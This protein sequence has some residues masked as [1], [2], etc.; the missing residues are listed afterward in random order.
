MNE[1]K[2]TVN[3]GERLFPTSYYVTDLIDGFE[4][5]DHKLSQR[6][7]RVLQKAAFESAFGVTF[8][9]P[10]Y[11]KTRRLV[12]SNPDLIS[13][14]VAYGRSE[15]GIW[16]RFNRAAELG[17]SDTHS[18]GS[19][20]E[21]DIAQEDNQG[22]NEAT[23]EEQLQVPNAGNEDNLNGDVE[24]NIDWSQHCMYCDELLPANPSQQL[25]D[26][27]DDLDLRSVHDGVNGHDASLNPRH[28]FIQPIVQ[29]IK[30]CQR[31]WFELTDYPRAANNTTWFGALPV[32]FDSLPSRVRALEP[33]LNEVYMNPFD[34]AF[35]EDLSGHGLGLA[36][37]YASM[38]TTSAG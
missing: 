22:L 31:H 17:D 26:L 7:P 9:R 20:S 13:K 24:E 18:E 14:F 5:M 16:K 3:K 21:L 2:S 27:Q 28:R 30:Y 1:S 6:R 15:H 10:T 34:N 36:G 32:D 35:Y 25:L 4:D 33:Y 12:D 23:Q 38:S 37:E 11:Q 29:T 8:M 19:E